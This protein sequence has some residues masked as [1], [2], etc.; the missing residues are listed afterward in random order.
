MAKSILN[1]SDKLVIQ[2]LDKAGMIAEEISK[3]IEKDVK[4]VTQHLK[5]IATKINELGRKEI[6]KTKKLQK[7]EV[8]T[9]S[10]VVSRM[11]TKTTSGK[12]GIAMMTAAASEAADDIRKN[13]PANRTASKYEDD[14][15]RPHG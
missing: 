6:K 8:T 12:S 7:D 14:L 11:I 15:F 10:P 2:N 1:N 13:V 9:T 4:L 3:V 5:T